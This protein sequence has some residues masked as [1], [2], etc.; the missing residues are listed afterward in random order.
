MDLYLGPLCSLKSAYLLLLAYCVCCFYCH[1]CNL[2]SG[3][4]LPPAVFLLF[5]ITLTRNFGGTDQRE[6]V[7]C[8]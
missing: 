7:L 8:A 2:K 6:T 4:V 1:G 3:T 5:R